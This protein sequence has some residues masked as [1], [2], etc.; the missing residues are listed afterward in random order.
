MKIEKKHAF[1]IAGAI[2]LFALSIFVYAYGGSTPSVMGHSAGEIDWSNAISSNMKI[3]GSNTLEFGTN[4]AGK[5]INA[6]KIGYNVFNAGTGLANEL[7]IVGAGTSGGARYIRMWDG[8]YATDFC[9]IGGKCLSTTSSGGTYSVSRDLGW[10]VATQSCD[11][12]CGGGKTIIAYA[13]N[14]DGSRMEI[15]S[16]WSNGGLWGR[17]ICLVG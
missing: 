9:T 11:Q 6:G 14:P 3:D 10:H 17:C 13:Q 7:D 1:L 15:S 5:E 8:V 2:A 12:I 4:V 16:D